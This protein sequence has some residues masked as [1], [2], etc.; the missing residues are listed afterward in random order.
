MGTSSSGWIDHR[1][2]IPIDAAYRATVDRR[3]SA[4]DSK[5]VICP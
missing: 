2:L 1:S 4:P 5:R 3:V